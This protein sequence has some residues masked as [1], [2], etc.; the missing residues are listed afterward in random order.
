M[1]RQPA[2]NVHAF[3]LIEVIVRQ[4]GRK[5]DRLIKRRRRTGG[6]KIVE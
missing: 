6:F 3:N 1:R 2:P 4:N 5:L